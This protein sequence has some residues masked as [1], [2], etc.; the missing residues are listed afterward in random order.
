MS[1]RVALLI[2]L[3]LDQVDFVHLVL[4]IYNNHIKPDDR[5]G[6]ENRCD[7]DFTRVSR[8]PP[9]QKSHRA[10]DAKARFAR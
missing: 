2:E 7:G 5:E 1:G 6:V 9:R 4:E 3:G 10:Q 8:T